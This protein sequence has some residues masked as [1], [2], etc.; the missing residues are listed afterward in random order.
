MLLPCLTRGFFKG[1]FA[2]SGI[3]TAATFSRRLLLSPT[4]IIETFLKIALQKRSEQA[5][6]PSC[7]CCYCKHFLT[8]VFGYTKLRAGELC[9]SFFS[10]SFFNSC[11]WSIYCVQRKKRHLTICCK[12]PRWPKIISYV[13]SDVTG[14]LRLSKPHTRHINCWDN[15]KTRNCTKHT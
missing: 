8:A 3:K 1:C 12:Y 10:T 2:T 15:T 5:V 6:A 14:S 13:K 9:A 11:R 7:F 4:C